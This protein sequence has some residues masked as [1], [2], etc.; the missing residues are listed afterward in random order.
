MSGCQ[1]TPSTLF[2]DHTCQQCPAAYHSAGQI[3]T[4]A[5][6]SLQS[7]IPLSCPPGSLCAPPDEYPPK[8]PARPRSPAWQLNQ[9]RVRR[10]PDQPR[11]HLLQHHIDFRPLWPCPQV[12]SYSRPHRLAQHI[13]QR[14][15]VVWPHLTSDIRCSTLNPSYLPQDSTSGAEAVAFFRTVTNLFKVNVS[16]SSGFVST[17]IFVLKQYN[18]Y[19][20]LTGITPSKERSYSRDGFQSALSNAFGVSTSY[21][22]RLIMMC[23]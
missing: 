16:A 9:L 22:P 3:S 23:R 17:H 7:V 14:V 2:V 8:T 5:C 6:S 18:I 20:V 21:M 1:C 12:S 4:L 11:T 15:F 13:P 19:H 10:E